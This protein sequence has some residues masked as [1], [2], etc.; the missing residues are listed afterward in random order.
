MERTSGLREFPLKAAI[1]PAQFRSHD[2]ASHFLGPAGEGGVVHLENAV[3]AGRVVAEQHVEDHGVVRGEQD[4]LLGPGRHVLQFH[5]PRHELVVEVAG[6]RQLHLRGALQRVAGHLEGQALLL[7]PI[8][9]HQ[10]VDHRLVVRRVPDNRI[11]GRGETV[12]AEELLIGGARRGFGA[13][14]DLQWFELHLEVLV[15]SVVEPH[16]ELLLE[17]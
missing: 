8:L 6:H 5:D 4:L 7:L 17:L 9:A 3:A 15:I 12:V 11:G 2:S 16:A 10:D 14:V 13:S 1:P